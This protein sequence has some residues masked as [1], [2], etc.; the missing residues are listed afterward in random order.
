MQVESRG[1]KSRDLVI[2][3]AQEHLC[4][5]A[6]LFNINRSSFFCISF[7]IMWM[8][9]CVLV[10]AVDLCFRFAFEGVCLISG[11]GL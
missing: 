4:K 10:Y 2:G 6:F 7:C 1:E 5:E 9:W 3:H 8:P 11:E